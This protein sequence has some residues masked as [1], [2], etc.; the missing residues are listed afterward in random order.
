[1]I[2]SIVRVAVAQR[3]LI[4][5]LMLVWIG[6]GAWSYRSLPIDAVPDLSLIHI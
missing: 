1:M 4:L 5:A 2:N 3:W 6:I